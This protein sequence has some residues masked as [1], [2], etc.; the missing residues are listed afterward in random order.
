MYQQVCAACHSM[1]RV[2]FRNLVG[3]CYN[4]E[5]AKVCVCVGHAAACSGGPQRRSAAAG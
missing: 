1:E 2:A 3:V 5:E 4:E